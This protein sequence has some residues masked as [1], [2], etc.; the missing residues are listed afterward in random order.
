MQNLYACDNTVLP[1]LVVLDYVALHFRA[2]QPDCLRLLQDI[3]EADLELDMYT[4]LNFH[5]V[6]IDRMVLLYAHGHALPVLA[7][8]ASRAASGSMDLTLLRHF[9]A[10]SL[11]VAAPPFSPSFVAAWCD[12]L[13]HWSARDDAL[14]APLRA[15]LLPFAGAPPLPSAASLRPTM[16]MRMAWR[17][18]AGV[19]VLLMREPEHH[20]GAAAATADDADDDALRGRFIRCGKRPEKRAG[21]HADGDDSDAR[22]AIRAAP[23]AAELR[24]IGTAARRG[25]PVADPNGAQRRAPQIVRCGTSCSRSTRMFC[26]ASCECNRILK[27]ITVPVLGVPYRLLLRAIDG[28]RAAA[29]RFTIP[30]PSLWARP[31]TVGLLLPIRLRRGDFDCHGRCGVISRP[32]CWGRDEHVAAAPPTDVLELRLLPR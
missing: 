8:V 32:A 7:Y 31:W 1:P 13:A 10:E 22:A 14:P 24:A 4:A 9:I 6:L 21:G 11:G 5:T 19:R 23:H 18:A 2:L 26:L 20:V 27:P 16:R 28:P 25:E 3:L 12:V 29:D 17:G 15:S 30:S